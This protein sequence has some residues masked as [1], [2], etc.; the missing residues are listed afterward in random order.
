MI[1]Q[2]HVTSR[3]RER[4]REIKHIVTGTYPQPRGWTTPSS[5]WRA[6]GWWRWPLERDSPLQQGAG[7]GLDWFSVATEAFGG[8]TPDLLCSLVFLGYMDIYRRKKS[9]R[10]ATRD[11]RG[12]R[13]RPLPR[14]FLVDPLTCTPSLLYC[15]LSKNNFSEGFIPFGF[16][17]IFLFFK[18]LKQGKN[19]NW[20]CAPGY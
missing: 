6:P 1:H 12:W 17:L 9:V 18:T 14:G 10:G 8:G 2:D 20:H 19:R 5:S 16:C 3:T 15:F 4:E 11:P 7:T 13:A